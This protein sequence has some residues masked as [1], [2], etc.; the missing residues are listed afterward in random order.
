MGL[1]GKETQGV[2]ERF[3]ENHANFPRF[4]VTRV[5]NSTEIAQRNLFR[6][7]F[8]CWG[9]VV[10]FGWIS[11]CDLGCVAQGCHQTTYGVPYNAPYHLPC[12]ADH[13]GVPCRAPYRAKLSRPLRALHHSARMSLD[14]LSGPLRLRVQS[15]SRAR[16][17]IAASIAFLFRAYFEGVWDTIAQLS[18]G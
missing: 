2:H 13:D 8:L 11:S 10:S 4:P 9:G 3:R 14:E 17:R 15:R 16:L 5:R 7:T 1:Q 6:Q 18:R 12:R